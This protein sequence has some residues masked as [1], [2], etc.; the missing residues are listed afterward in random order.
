MNLFYPVLFDLMLALRS[1]ETQYYSEKSGPILAQTLH[2]LEYQSDCEISQG[3]MLSKFQ[4]TNT[5]KMATRNFLPRCIA[6]YDR[7]P[8]DSLKISTSNAMHL[9]KKFLGAIFGAIVYSND[10]VD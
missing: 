9:G 5:L 6:F 4:Y 10:A 7:I 2:F 3:T 1:I 8:I